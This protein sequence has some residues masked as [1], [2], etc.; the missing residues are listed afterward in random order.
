MDFTVDT[1]KYEDREGYVYTL[2]RHNFSWD[3]LINNRLSI[4]PGKWRELYIPSMPFPD[5]PVIYRYTGDASEED[6]E[7]A[8]QFAEG[9]MHIVDELKY[10]ANQLL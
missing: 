2:S 10:R 9:R 6:R 7:E 3:V 8:R 4:T 1:I 5:N